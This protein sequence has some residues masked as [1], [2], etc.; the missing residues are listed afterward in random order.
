MSSSAKRVEDSYGDLDEHYSNGSL[1]ALIDSLRYSKAD[2]KAGKPNPTKLSIGGNPYNVLNNFRSSL[3]YYKSFMDQGGAEGLVQE[4]AIEHA[5]EIIKSDKENKQFEVE[6]HLQEELRKEI[7]QLET[8][9]VIIDGGN[10]L[11][12]E[13]GNIDI[14]AED[15][16]GRAV[17]IELKR[18]VAKR[19]AIG[20]IAG[21]MGDL[22]NDEGFDKVRGIL[23]AAAFDKSCKS[24]VKVIPNL[25]L[26][27]YRFN[28]TFEDPHLG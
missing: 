24:A 15:S 16:F 18:G 14:L 9:L 4:A 19:E 8:G 5:A 23:V 3:K 28:F 21:Y 26:R 13:S 22:V 1:D 25:E 11:G 7:S 27:T 17:V 6:R 20:Q 2:E 12:V 10:E